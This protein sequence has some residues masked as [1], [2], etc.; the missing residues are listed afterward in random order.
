M[1][2]LLVGAWGVGGASELLHLATACGREFHTG[3]L[4]GDFYSPGQ[5][6]GVGGAPWLG[7]PADWWMMLCSP[8]HDAAVTNPLPAPNRTIGPLIRS[9][10]QMA[11]R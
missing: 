11:L 3:P 10:D 7:S 2:W 6:V 5:G 9:V 4:T 8:G 1:R